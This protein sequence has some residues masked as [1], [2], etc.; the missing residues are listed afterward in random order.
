MIFRVSFP[1][2]GINIVINSII[3]RIGVLTI[4]WYGAIIAASFLIALLYILYRTKD[5]GVDKNILYDIV[6]LSSIIAI[7]GARIYYILFY[8]SDYYIKNPHKIIRIDEGGIAIY[9]AIIFGLLAILL[10]CKIKK[11]R[12]FPILD[13][14]SMGLVLGQSIGRWGNFVNQEAFGTET[15]L[16]WAM[17]SENT[18]GK[19]VHPCFLYESIGCL[20]IFFILHMYSKSKLYRKSGSVF[21]MYAMLY[22]ILRALIEPIRTDSLMLMNTD[23][24]ISLLLS[25]LVVFAS[26]LLIVYDSICRE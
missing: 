26:S 11:Q 4:R 8:P 25:I 16:P 19:A 22:G 12:I 3:C 5:F 13:L 23:V 24:K 6:F 21:Y 2:L 10:I 17:V 15:T 7:I 9:G 1:N 14:L 20:V 18:L